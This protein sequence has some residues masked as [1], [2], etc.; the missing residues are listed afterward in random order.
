M[1]KALVTLLLISEDCYKRNDDNDN[2]LDNV[3]ERCGILPFS[4]GQTPILILISFEI[5]RRF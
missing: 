5:A 2:V 4:S 3:E 1:R